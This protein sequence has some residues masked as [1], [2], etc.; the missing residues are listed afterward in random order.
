[1]T[2]S[3]F[4]CTGIGGIGGGFLINAIFLSAAVA[5]RYSIFNIYISNLSY[6]NINQ[7]RALWWKSAI[8]FIGISLIIFM[9]NKWTIYRSNKVELRV[10]HSAIKPK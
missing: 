7:D 4:F 6:T 5:N 2:I 10:K 3:N 9:L 1:M 8:I